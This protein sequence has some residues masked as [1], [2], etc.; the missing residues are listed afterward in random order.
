MPCWV[1]WPRPIYGDPSRHLGVVGVTGTAGKTTTCYLLEAALAADGSTT[2][3]IGT[4]ET[5]IDG[6]V[7]PSALTTPEAPDLQALFAVMLERGVRV[8]AMEVSSHALSLGRVAGTSYAVGAFSNLSQDHLDFHHDMEDY[9]AAKSMLFDGRAARHVIMVDDV[10]GRRLAAAHPDALTVSSTDRATDHPPIPADWSV[11]DVEQRAGGVQHVTLQGP[12][13]RQVTLDL[14]LPGAFNVANAALALACVDALGRDVQRAAKAMASIAVPGRMERVVAGQ[15]YLAVVDYAHKPAALAAVLDAI[16]EGLTGRLIV[17]IG[18][19]GARDPGKRP[20]MGAETARRADL[21]IVT[22]DNPRSEDPAEIRRQVLDGARRFA[23]ARHVQILEIGDRR[24]AI[25][26]AVA[27]ARSGDAVVIAGKGHEQGQDVGGVIHP[28]SDRQELHRPRSPPRWVPAAHDRD[29]PRAGRRRDRPAG[30]IRL[31]RCL[32]AVGGVRHPPDH[33]RRAVRRAARGAR[34]RSRLR[35][36][37]RGRPERSRCSARRRSTRTCRCCG[38]PDDPAN[39]AVLAALGALARASV[40]ALVREHGLEVIGVTG[41][42]GKTSTKDLI[43]AVLTSAVDD[44][45]RVIAPP[46]SFNNELGHPYTALRATPDTRFLVLELSARGIG[47][48]C[49][50]GPGGAAADRCGAQRRIGAHRRIR[51][52]RGHRHREIRT[53]A[54]TSVRRRRRRGDPER[55]RPAGAAD[56]RGD[57]RAGGAGRHQPGRDRPSAGRRPGRR[58]HAPGSPWSPRRAARRSTLGV[59]GAHQVGNALTAAAVG[60]AVGMDV[61]TVAAALSGDAGRLPVADGDHRTARR[62]HRDQRRL[63]RQP[64]LDEGRPAALSQIGRGR[65]TWAVL[66][67]MAEL[68]P[69]TIPAHDQIGR[70]VVRLGHRPADRWSGPARPGPAAAPEPAPCTWGRIWKG[71]GAVSRCR[72][73]TPWTTPRRS[74]RRNWSRETW[75]WSR[76]HGPPVW[77]RVALRLIADAPVRPRPGDRTAR[78]RAPAPRP[79]RPAGEDD[80]HRGDRRARPSPSCSPPT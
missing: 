2:G 43:A 9:F 15:D 34:R 69:E 62:H 33:P 26:A 46:E 73:P 47:H 61:G 49:D 21:V 75:C 31:G 22:D 65:R 4:V 55:R 74:S 59:I 38:S 12:G 17:V 80:P 28:F 25:R 39:T 44:P 67:E 3:L 8:V 19:G 53:G 32:R 29:E 50:A 68:G 45:G 20:M 48:I 77:R 27:A 6:E 64:A 30:R 60:R 14:A 72:S 51:L 35:R 52:R 10:W 42:S 13:G 7:A 41:S 5:R 71:R 56:G 54:I 1:R 66:G 78:R 36:R 40:T 11:L 23:E 16:S 37:R 70:L 24:A 57:Q 18:A 76:H 63:Q 79:G 58:R